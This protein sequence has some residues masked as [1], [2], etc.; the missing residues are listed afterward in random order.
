MEEKSPSPRVSKPSRDRVGEEGSLRQDSALNNTPKSKDESSNQAGLTLRRILL[1]GILIRLLFMP[2]T[3]STDLL[4]P[5]H[6]GYLWITGGNYTPGITFMIDYL[7]GIFLWLMRPFLYPYFHSMWNIPWG[8]THPITG[9]QVSQMLRT[10]F[11]FVSHPGIFRILFFLKL[12]YLFFDVACAFLLLKSTGR[13]AFRFW[14]LNPVI[15]FVS[16]IYGRYEVIAIFF[17]ILS[18]YLWQKDLRELSFFALGFSALLRIYPLLL[19]PF[20]LVAGR[21]KPRR[22]PA[23]ILAGLIPIL[24]LF[25]MRGGANTGI[26]QLPY[27]DYLLSMNFFLGLHSTLYIFVIG[28][29]LL[30][31]CFFYSGKGSEQGIIYYL[32]L[33]FLFLFATTYFHAQFYAWLIPFLAM[34]VND[35]REIERFF[36]FSLIFYFL[37]LFQWGRVNSVYLFAPLNPARIASMPSLSEL[38][39]PQT[40]HR[41]MGL[42]RS[43]LSASLFWMMFML[44][45]RK[46]RETD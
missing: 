24:P 16:S 42:V 27:L 17:I 4:W 14:M 40:F 20:F 36:Y 39:N 46:W 34:V 38:L 1:W 18:V 6:R 10:F 12:P 31:F 33:F 5:Y 23:S 26:T 45:R 9:Q 7:H 2:F 29:L 28:Y 41:F 35:N 44:A 21:D 43:A 19:F 22:L 8:S 11:T 13:N 37:Y 15:I 25:L 3:S 32:T 30:L